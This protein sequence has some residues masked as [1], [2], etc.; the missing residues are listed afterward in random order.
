MLLHLT[1]RTETEVIVKFPQPLTFAQVVKRI[2]SHSRSQ[3]LHG[4]HVDPMMRFSAEREYATA[5]A[6]LALRATVLRLQTYTG[7]D[8]DK[9]FQTIPAGSTS[10]ST[11]RASTH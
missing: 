11:R 8:D 1:G 6:R 9:A 3:F 4:N 5:L 2:Y 7:S 10:L